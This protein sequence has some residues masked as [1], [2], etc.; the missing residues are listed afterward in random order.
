MTYIKCD[1]CGAQIHP[2]DNH[3]TITVMKNFEVP[4]ANAKSLIDL[5]ETCS[6][7]FY[8]HFMKNHYSYKAVNN[9]RAI[10]TV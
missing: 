4:V 2:L 10:K 6:K 1:R 7:Q 5:C 9:E 3:L 8:T